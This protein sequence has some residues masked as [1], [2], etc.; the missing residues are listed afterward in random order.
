MT[1]HDTSGGRPEDGAAAE[2]ADT[3]E[4]D[5]EAEAAA[6]QASFVF[7]MVRGA[8]PDPVTHRRNALRSLGLSER[9]VE[10]LLRT[11]RVSHPLDVALVRTLQQRE[12]VSCSYPLQVLLELMKKI[13]AAARTPWRR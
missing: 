5:A 8:W 3:A 13:E 10:E 9:G 12:D 2:P 4:P 11:V 1:T 7:G 6:A